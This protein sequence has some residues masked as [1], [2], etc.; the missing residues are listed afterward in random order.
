MRAAA[1]AAVVV[2]VV[3]PLCWLGSGPRVALAD[4][5]AA[6]SGSAKPTASAPPPA[7]A[8]PAAG[9]KAWSDADGFPAVTSADPMWG[10]RVAPATLVVFS[11]LECRFCAKLDQTFEE[12]KKQYGPSKLRIVFKH[13]PLD[14]H[15]GARPGAIAA[16]TVHKLGGSA[17]FFQFTQLAFADQKNL[18]AANFNLWA[19]Q[20]G[21]DLAKVTKAEVALA[22]KKVDA[23][24][25]EGKSA[26]VTGTPATFVNGTLLSGAQKTESFVAAIDQEL[27]KAAKLKNVAPDRVYVKLSREAKRKADAE[28]AAKQRKP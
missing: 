6:P 5:P 21:V 9:A 27:A 20:A 22:E 1:L 17:A 2:S 18:N 23:D 12:L 16:A 10:S 24:L 25:A 28:K 15:K 13:H 3:A 19:K 7:S 8:K 26:G 14:F 4:P 11:D